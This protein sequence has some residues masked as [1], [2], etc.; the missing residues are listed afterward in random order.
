[1]VLVYLVNLFTKEW[2]MLQAQEI[3]MHF[4][5]VQS[6]SICSQIANSV[7]TQFANILCPKS[8]DFMATF[9]IQIC[10]KDY[11][12]PSIAGTQYEQS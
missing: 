10:D 7:T 6:K 2:M 1:M 5:M 8:M 4:Y 11:S 12:D 3:L 9:V